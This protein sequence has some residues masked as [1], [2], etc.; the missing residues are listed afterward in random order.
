V[1]TY[2]TVNDP[3][4]SAFVL[5]PEMTH[6][7]GHIWKGKFHTVQW[8]LLQI[9]YMVNNQPSYNFKMLEN[10]RNKSYL[11]FNITN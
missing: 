3:S 1:L 4:N 2:V 11:L 8:Q 10:E 5:M 9:V 6:F 7:P